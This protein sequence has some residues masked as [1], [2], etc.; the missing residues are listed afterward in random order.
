MG[1]NRMS[2]AEGAPQ[3]ETRGTLRLRNEKA[4]TSYS[5][6]SIVTSTPEEVVVSFGLNVSPPTAEREV[7]VE[8][9]DRIVMSYPTAKRLAITLG[10]VIQ[11]YEQVR[12]VIQLG[13]PA[14]ATPETPPA[15]AGA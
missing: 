4:V 10:Q 9:T 5:N 2:E 11:R 8:V 15:Q 7:S 6:F 13:P 12:G 1:K 3:Q 14:A